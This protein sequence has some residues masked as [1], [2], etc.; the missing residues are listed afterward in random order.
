MWI[1]GEKL[2]RRGGQ[3]NA[4]GKV[5]DRQLGKRGDVGQ[6]VQLLTAL[7][8]FNSLYINPIFVPV[9]DRRLFTLFPQPGKLQTGNLRRWGITQRAASAARAIIQTNS[10]VLLLSVPPAGWS[11]WSSPP[12]GTAAPPEPR[13]AGDSTGRFPLSC[14]RVSDGARRAY[15]ICPYRTSAVL[16]GI[17]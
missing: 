1:V 3:A 11:V 12:A 7:M 15:A 6:G 2:G 17:R 13:T 8:V 5:F 16:T 10:Y 14:S 4:R 9:S